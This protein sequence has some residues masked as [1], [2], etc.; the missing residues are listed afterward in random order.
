MKENKKMQMI[1]DESRRRF[2]KNTAIAAAGF[3]IVPRHVL[4]GKGYVA[5]SDRLLIAGIGA[6]GKAGDDVNEFSK[7]PHAEIAYLCDVDDR[8]AADLRKN[9]LRL[10]ITRTGGNYMRK[11][12]KILMRCL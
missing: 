2:V 11:K 10:N 12:V 6:G 1:P 8:Q 3:V 5:P 7:S 4:G 9:F